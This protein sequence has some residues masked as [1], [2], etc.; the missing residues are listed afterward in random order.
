MAMA[1]EWTLFEIVN[2]MSG[3]SWNGTHDRSVDVTYHDD[4]RITVDNNYSSHHIQKDFTLAQIIDALDGLREAR[5]FS[6]FCQSFASAMP[7]AKAI[8]EDRGW[9]ATGLEIPATSTVVDREMAAGA[10]ANVAAFKP[11]TLG[12]KSDK[13][14]ANGPKPFT[15][16]LKM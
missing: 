5:Y 16:K 13:P 7:G 4:N 11:L 8:M 15:L 2:Q 6:E 9:Y 1:H 14:A 3:D 12:P 10:G